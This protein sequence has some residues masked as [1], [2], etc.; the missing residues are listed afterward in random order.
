MSC[1]MSYLSFCFFPIGQVA[2]T[3]SHSVQEKRLCHQPARTPPQVLGTSL[4]VSHFPR[5]GTG[6][7][8]T[9]LRV[10]ITN[11][12]NVLVFSYAFVQT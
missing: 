1:S 3:L 10:L 12:Q 11:Y 6:W 4:G 7:S 2:L 9:C 5:G 8:T